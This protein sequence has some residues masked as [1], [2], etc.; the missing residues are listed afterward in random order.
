MDK[1]F[2]KHLAEIAQYMQECGVDVYPFPSVMLNKQPQTGNTLFNT[3]G[4]YDPTDKVIVLFTHGRH[5]KDILRSYAHE[6]IHHNQNLSGL[7]TP[8][9][10][11]EGNDPKYAQNNPHMRKLEEDAY[12]RGNMLFRD[13]TDN[14][15]YGKQ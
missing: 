13:W 3:T 2:K 6:L 14:K 7:M 8:D 10:M 5:M 11:G 4:Y 9:K 12:Q 1:S 15:K